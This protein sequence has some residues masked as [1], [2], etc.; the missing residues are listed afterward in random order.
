MP[1]YH[2]MLKQKLVIWSWINTNYHQTWSSHRHKLYFTFEMPARSR[3]F[4]LSSFQIELVNH[5]CSMLIN[6]VFKCT[7]SISI[8]IPYQQASIERIH[9]AAIFDGYLMLFGYRG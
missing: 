5:G 4:E 9:H 1:V 8:E 6:K 7:L 2:D 3:G